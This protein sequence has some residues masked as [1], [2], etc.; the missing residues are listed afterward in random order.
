[1]KS[2]RRKQTTKPCRACS[3]RPQATIA[4]SAA[5][6]KK[7]RRCGPKTTK[8][9]TFIT[10]VRSSIIYPCLRIHLPERQPI[11]CAPSRS[12]GSGA[13]AFGRTC[14]IHMILPGEASTT[15]LCVWPGSRV[16][17]RAGRTFTAA[18][19]GIV[20]NLVSSERRSRFFSYPCVRVDTCPSCDR[21]LKNRSS[22]RF[23]YPCGA[24]STALPRP[25]SDSQSLH[26]TFLPCSIF[27]RTQGPKQPF[28]Q[29][30]N[31]TER[32]ALQRRLESD[33]Q[34]VRS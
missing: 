31:N 15:V 33:D 7:R 19:C 10:R 24:P 9:T 13:N 18:P 11:P 5:V 22:C 28:Q 3:A 14:R 6:I 34:W 4:V 12:R 23:F 20:A 32:V 2:E 21:G 25:V 17:S 1:M 30:C 16:R 27:V 8:R 29:Y 26:T